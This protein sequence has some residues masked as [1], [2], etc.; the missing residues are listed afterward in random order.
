MQRR[1]HTLRKVISA[2]LLAVCGIIT[3]QAGSLVTLA[4]I[5]QAVK[6]FVMQ[7]QVPLNDV[8]V[9][10]TSFSDEL[11]LSR[12]L[13]PMQISIAP[14]AKLLGQTS[15]AVSCNT[16]QQWKIHI[17]AHIDGQVSALVALHPITRGTVIQKADLEF[18]SRRYS[19]L[20]YGYYT[21]ANQLSGMEA[22]RNI[23]AG[24]VIT[25]GQLNA[26]KMVVRG[27]HV[28]I[29]AERGGLDLRVKGKALMDGRQ[30]QTIQVKNLNS[31]KLIYAQVVGSGMVKVN[32]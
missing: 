7:Q 3:V 19:Q 20:H 11:K 21:S 25:P 18:S 12:C 24:Q 17:A 15:L 10:V 9:T 26:Q 30:G 32:F 8:Q 23:R 14:G 13:E 5:N 31:Q 4:E 29:I 2:S 16:P 6:H 1:S 27:Q 28:T 22:K